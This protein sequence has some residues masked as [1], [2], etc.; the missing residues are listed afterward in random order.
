MYIN[1]VLMNELLNFLFYKL[2]NKYKD[3]NEFICQLIELTINC[4]KL[5]KKGN[6]ECLHLESYTTSLMQLVI[7]YN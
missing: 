3:N 1:V 4:D 6:K 5:L 2:L 7:Q